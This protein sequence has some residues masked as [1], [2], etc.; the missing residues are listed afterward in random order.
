MLKCPICRNPNTKLKYTI[1]K[2]TYYDCGICQTLFLHPQPTVKQLAEYYKQE[3]IYEAGS[4]YE[5]R[6]R[7]QAKRTLK[8]LKEMNLTGK[9]LLDIG[10]GLGYFLDEA[11]KTGLDATG[12]EPSKK[13]AAL[14]R[15]L[16][17]TNVINADLELFFKNNR[18]KKYDF[19]T[20]INVIEHFNNPFKQIAIVSKLL[21]KDGILYLE[22][23][24]YNSWLYMIEKEKYTFLTPP[25]HTYI[26]SSVSFSFLIKNDSS[27]KTR[28]TLTYSYPEHLMGILKNLLKNKK[29]QIL[30]NDSMQANKEN[31][32]AISKSKTIKYMLFDKALSMI[33]YK[34]LNYFNYGSFLE[35]YIRKI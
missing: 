21:K 3:F 34:I 15:K 25:D 11:Q 29:N 27:L 9:S 32:I 7:D 14:S 26:F 23:P 6:I 19:I 4:Q 30:L 16:Y 31:N 8:N 12:I 17:R 18:H 24:N 10:S 20:M 2:Y 33:S 22:T 1:N 35:L 5:K 28:D 13:F